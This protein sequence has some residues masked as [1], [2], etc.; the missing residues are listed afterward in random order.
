MYIPSMKTCIPEPSISLDDLQYLSNK[1]KL[2]TFSSRARTPPPPSEVPLSGNNSS[3]FFAPPSPSIPFYQ[4]PP[5]SSSSENISSSPPPNEPA[6]PPPPPPLWREVGRLARDLGFEYG[7]SQAFHLEFDAYDN[8][9]YLGFQDLGEPEHLGRPSIVYFDGKNWQVTQ[10]RGA[11]CQ[12]GSFP[13]AVI[14]YT[15]DYKVRRVN[16]N[17]KMFIGTFDFTKHMARFYMYDL[18]TNY[19]TKIRN[20]NVNYFNMISEI[21][22]RVLWDNLTDPIFV[23]SNDVQYTTHIQKY[24]YTSDEWINMQFG[25]YISGLRDIAL[26]RNSYNDQI[27]VS[28]CLAPWRG[29]L[30]PMV[31]RFEDYTMK[32][33][34]ITK[35]ND[36]ENSHDLGWYAN[37]C[38][39]SFNGYGEPI[40]AYVSMKNNGESVI[41]MKY[42]EKSQN[43][44]D[45][46]E[47][48]KEDL[49]NTEKHFKIFWDGARLTMD[50]DKNIYLYFRSHYFSGLS[51]PM[52]DV[53]A[54]LWVIK[55]DK[56][57]ISSWSIW[58]ED[59][60][61]L[62][63]T[64][65]I[66]NT[67]QS[68]DST[69]GHFAFDPV[70][71]P[72]YAFCK[73]SFDAKPLCPDQP[74]NYE[75]CGK[76]VQSRCAPSVYR[77]SS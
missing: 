20:N 30:Y 64:Y 10:S 63:G 59:L 27:Y 47:I 48:V 32:W 56:Y 61:G 72:Y 14:R 74:A 67:D 2:S 16:N 28:G 1:S 5:I 60:D 50:P 43:W 69:M 34:N 75:F 19:Y 22:S 3:R 9:P 70:G 35:P 42:D 23:S 57:N 77:L 40:S 26:V 68:L 15:I 25:A 37:F 29:D 24:N 65:P 21:G 45:M 8:T 12:T 76:A 7:P 54:K 18:S 51:W 4:D 13:L 11:P 66:F 58:N 33:E 62:Y 31:Y 55:L 38:D 71:I 52:I 36:Y 44:D 73:D 53:D 46:L 17:T 41:I 49:P 6:T 39:L